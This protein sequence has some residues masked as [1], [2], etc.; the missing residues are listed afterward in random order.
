MSYI[1]IWEYEVKPDLI[2]EFTELYGPHGE[3]ETLF[4]QYEGYEYTLLLNDDGDSTKFV[5]ID[6][7]DSKESF[8]SFR[9]KAEVAF[10]AIDRRGDQIT[11]I[12]RKIGD[13]E[14]VD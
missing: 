5:T 8:E 1:Y 3:W 11:V 6:A 10:Y 14:T 7:W 4:K 9:S 12:E 2:D 13:F